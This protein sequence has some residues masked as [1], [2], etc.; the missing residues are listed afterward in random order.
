M[1][2][3]F[4]YSSANLFSGGEVSDCGKLLLVTVRE[5][6]KTNKLFYA[7]IDGQKLDGELE[8][9]PI[10][11]NFKF[12]YSYVTNFGDDII[13]NTNNK[14]PNYKLIKVNLNDISEEKWT[15]LVPQHK[16]DV[17]ESCFCVH[18]DILCVNLI[19]DVHTV[20]ELRNALDGSLIKEVE[21]PIGSVPSMSGK[22][23]QSEVFF[24]FTSFLTPSLTYHIDFK[25][26][27]DAKVSKHLVFVV[28]L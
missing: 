20:I 22:K 6:L 4:S 17:L 9:K 25:Q 23:N 24:N 13:L 3:I 8:L 26:G 21:I 10:I 15:D 16:T 28:F 27:Y 19:R 1:Q 5:T 2:S 12:D 11:D 7:K 14:A 18:N